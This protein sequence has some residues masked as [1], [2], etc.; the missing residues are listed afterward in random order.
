VLN[1][2]NTIESC[3]Y[4]TCHVLSGPKLESVANKET[5]RVGNRGWREK[6]N[7]GI[8]RDTCSYLIGCPDCYNFNNC[9]SIILLKNNFKKKNIYIKIHDFFFSI[10]RDLVHFIWT[11]KKIPSFSLSSSYYIFLLAN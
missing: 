4:A 11:Q 3:R 8:I 1:T 2:F 9:T 6:K 5:A 7:F 10:N